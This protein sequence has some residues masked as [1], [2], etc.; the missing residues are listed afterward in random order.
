MDVLGF[1]ADNMGHFTLYDIPNV[2]FMMFA[3]AFLGYALARWG[4]RSHVGNARV[5]ALWAATAALAAAFVRAQLPLA[6]LLLALVLLVK[7]E[8]ASIRER[9]LLFGALVLGA[10]CG[11]GAALI[12]FLVA[13]PYIL[14]VRWALP[15]DKA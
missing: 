10:G 6:V 2:F 5:L 8:G 11:S 13:V 9:L 4:G 14:L 12:M 15:G 1:V 3:G 7:G